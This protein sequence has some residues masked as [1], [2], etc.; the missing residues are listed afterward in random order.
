MNEAAA[1]AYVAENHRGVLATFMRDG[2]PQLSKVVYG[3][4]DDGRLMISTTRQR[5]KTHNLRRDRRAS[6]LVSGENW[7]QYV[8]AEGLVEVY[9]QGPSLAADLR[10]YYERATGGP[11]PNW[12]EYDEAMVREQRLLVLLR[13]DRLYPV[14]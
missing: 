9:D 10:R 8:V 1:R 14:S 6:L 12:Q 11:H 3:V 4:D 7:W 2:R 5:A 13:I